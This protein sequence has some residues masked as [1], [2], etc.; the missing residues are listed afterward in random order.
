MK[1]L[2]ILL[3]LPIAIQAQVVPVPGTGTV[4]TCI[5]QPSSGLLYSENG[6]KQE[7]AQFSCVCE[8]GPCNRD[9]LLQA[10]WEHG[11][12]T[13]DTM[14]RLSRKANSPRY[15]RKSRVLLGLQIISYGLPFVAGLGEIEEAWIKT[16]FAAGPSMVKGATDLAQ[17]QPDQFAESR[18][19]GAWET[20]Y[21]APS[22]LT[23]FQITMT[24]P[25]ADPIL[26][27]G[28][29][30]SQ[31]QPQAL[32]SK[33]VPVMLFDPIRAYQVPWQ[34]VLYEPCSPPRPSSVI[35][36]E[37]GCPAWWDDPK[38]RR[39]ESRIMIAGLT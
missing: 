31:P 12:L 39:N 34:P 38:Y 15:S 29:I 24:P 23:G 36:D 21:T 14:E 6:K 16:L 30:D 33:G 32:P 20:V 26:V 11:P 4:A 7:A 1:L 5:R 17:S 37:P 13:A 25:K 18:A 8:P 2:L 22:K 3:L 35:S 28:I 27:P 9:R 19:P 10:M